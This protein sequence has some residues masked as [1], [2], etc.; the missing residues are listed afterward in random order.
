MLHIK[1]GKKLHFYLSN[2]KGLKPI[3]NNIKELIS[4]SKLNEYVHFLDEP[5]DDILI[6]YQANADMTIINKL[7]TEQNRFNFAT[8]IGEYLALGIPIITTNIGEVK[9]YLKDNVDCI[10]IQ[11][12]NYIEIAD[13]IAMLLDKKE[14]V[15]QISR[16]SRNI[17]LKHFSIDSNCYRLKKYFEQ[18]LEKS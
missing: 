5:N 2:K 4:K 10:Y 17:A 18:L 6:N 9:K 16:N 1:Y 12:N 15:Q 14:L 11:P 3:L 13:K 7:D 8:K